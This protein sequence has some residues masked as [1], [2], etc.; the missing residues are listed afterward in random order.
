[1]PDRIR[2]IGR[3]GL[4]PTRIDGRGSR[5]HLVDAETP[6]YTELDGQQRWGR[7]WVCV[8]E[9]GVTQ[10]QPKPL[11][12][13]DRGAP[14]CDK[15]PSRMTG[16]TFGVDL[17]NVTPFASH[18]LGLAEVTINRGAP[19]GST[20]NCSSP[21]P[22]VSRQHHDVRTFC[23]TEKSPIHGPRSAMAG[24]GQ[25]LGSCGVHR[26]MQWRPGSAR[27]GPRHCA[28]QSA[29]SAGLGREP[30]RSV[31]ESSRTQGATG[32]RVPLSG[33]R[34]TTSRVG[35]PAFAWQG[36]A[37]S[38]CLVARCCH[39][40]PALFT[41]VQMVCSS[42]QLAFLPTLGTVR[43]ERGVRQSLESS[44]QVE[45]GWGPRRLSGRC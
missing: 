2:V 26:A 31:Q 39:A 9:Q 27:T 11:G 4:V 15:E 21:W 45:P 8:G 37:T 30:L 18:K 10:W 13:C 32:Q 1:M 25:V 12:C 20:R 19:A 33:C 23:P 16:W 41:R 6:P 14:R 3:V 5:R 44:S 29:C 24:P 38:R 17:D 35:K 36:W 42:R 34:R 28:L 40:G 43:R 22:V 7:R